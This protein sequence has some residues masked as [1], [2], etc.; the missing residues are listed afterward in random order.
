MT[1]A[2]LAQLLAIDVEDPAAG[3]LAEDVSERSSR[4]F[5]QLNELQSTKISDG[6][7][8]TLEA[9]ERA[10]WPARLWAR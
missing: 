7:G 4:F 3:Q 6:I 10:R 5:A 8:Q 1:T 9:M 2:E